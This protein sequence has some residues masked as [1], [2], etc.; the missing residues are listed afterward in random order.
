MSEHWRIE[1]PV[2]KS[3]KG[4]LYICGTIKG[5]MQVLV[6][7]DRDAQTVCDYLNEVEEAAWKYRE[8]NK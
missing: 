8:L 6:V 4:N 3:Q 2:I 5:R 7:D 1:T